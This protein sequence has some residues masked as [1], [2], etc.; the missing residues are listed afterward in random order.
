MS[1]TYTVADVAAKLNLKPQKVGGEVEYHGAN[2]TGTGATKD[3]FFLREDGSGQDRNGT[4]YKCIDVAAMAGIDPNQ[5][6]PVAEFRARNGKATSNGGNPNDTGSAAPRGAAKPKKPA[7]DWNAATKFDYHDENG[8]LRYQV[9]RLDFPDGSKDFRQR[10]PDGAGGWIYNLDGVARVLFNLADVMAAGEVIFCE[11]EKTATAWNEDLKA[12]NLYGPT[13]ATTTAQGA[14]NTL[15]TDLLPLWG[16]CVA[17]SPDNNVQGEKQRDDLL[18]T[19]GE[20]ATCKVIELPDRGD[21]GDYVDF[22]AAGGT[23]ETALEM[24]DAAPIWTPP[25]KEKRFSLLTLA[26]LKAKPKPQFLI[27]GILV[28]ADTSLLTAK[29]ASFKS[30]IALDMA[31]CVACNVPFHGYEVARGPVVYIA[32]EGAV[33]LTKRAQAWC[34]H[35]DGADPGENFVV[36]DSPI[37]I[38][39]ARTRADLIEEIAELN[40]VLVVLD[41][42]ARCA[43]GL[44]ENSSKDM[45]EFADAL[46]ALAKESGAHVLTVHHNNKGGDYRGSSAIPAAVG[47]HLSLERTGDTVT[48]KT[49]KQK[50]AEELQDLVFEKVEVSIPGTYGEEISLVFEKIDTRPGVGDS[51]G[52]M[53][54]KVLEEFKAAFSDDGATFSQWEKVC[55]FAGINE[56][57]FKR[58][59]KEL[60]QKKIVVCPNKGTRGARYLLVQ[61]EAENS[62]GDK[63]T[64]RGHDTLSPIPSNEGDIGD[65]PLY[66][67]SPCPLLT[68]ERENDFAATETTEPEPE[69][70]TPKKKRKGDKGDT[71]NFEP[72]RT[73][74]TEP[75]P[76]AAN[77]SDD[78]GER[79]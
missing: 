20:R 39:D 68:S 41:T 67:V 71:A 49:E 22:R 60:V 61:K 45:G 44:E 18:S 3:G 76:S 74:P 35:H 26:Q 69:P 55:G 24:I 51:L 9:G 58:A 14:G 12:A 53:A 6:E 43:V 27:H 19:I 52:D 62:E 79:F 37:Q 73:P 7:F 10:Q 56:R 46:D 33:G 16:K 23:L 54:E 77:D 13:V 72:Y 31:L 38:H 4:F 75:N 70:K 25:A 65:T 11:G 1:A 59:A 8:V 21:G 28:K 78:D 15:K 50:D 34:A 30:F 29:H 32:A 57:T 40:P 64:N 48:L 5:Y 2:P 36:Y 63:G 47:T 42:L 66:R 17:I